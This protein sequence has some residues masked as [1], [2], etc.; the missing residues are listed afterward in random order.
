MM[1]GGGMMDGWGMMNPVM[2]IFML[3]FWGFA[4]FGLICA[5]RE[6]A[7]RGKSGKEKEAQESSLDILKKRYARGEI[8]KEEFERMRKDLE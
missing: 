3:L 7:N 6:L 2:W 8:G 4:I 1:H 5:F